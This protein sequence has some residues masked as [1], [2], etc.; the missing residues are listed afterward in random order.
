MSDGSTIAALF[1]V[2]T[3]VIT[4][5]CAIAARFKKRGHDQDELLAGRS[6]N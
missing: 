5:G 1:F 2:L 4:Y 6:L 3:L